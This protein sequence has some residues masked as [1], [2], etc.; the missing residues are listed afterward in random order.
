LGPAS[1]VAGA[2][3]SAAHGVLLWHALRAVVRTY[4]EFRDNAMA[5]LLYGAASGPPAA[6]S[7]PPTWSP[8]HPAADRQLRLATDAATAAGARALPAPAVPLP[9]RVATRV[10]RAW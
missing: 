9:A 6:N 1:P 8:T 10:L 3:Q 7:H 4:Q 5:T 2:G